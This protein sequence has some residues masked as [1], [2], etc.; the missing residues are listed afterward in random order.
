M[1]GSNAFL[2][3]SKNECYI[4]SLTAYLHQQDQEADISVANFEKGFDVVKS[5]LSGNNKKFSSILVS[6]DVLEPNLE[7]LLELLTNL[8]NHAGSCPITLFHSGSIDGETRKAISERV[9]FFKGM[10]R[11]DL[12][13]PDQTDLK[14]VIPFH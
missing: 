9:D 1:S 2:I 13:N 4:N 8:R 12:S 10:Q 5:Q 3:I 14:K 11:I 7:G 6:S